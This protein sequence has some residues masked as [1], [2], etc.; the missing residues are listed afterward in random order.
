MS[1]KNAEECQQRREQA[2]MERPLIWT[3]ATRHFKIFFRKVKLYAWHG[4][5]EEW[6][7]RRKVYANNSDYIFNF[8]CHHDSSLACPSPSLSLSRSPFCRFIFM[9]FMII[10]SKHEHIQRG[11]KAKLQLQISFLPYT[12]SRRFSHLSAQ[13]SR[14]QCTHILKNNFVKTV[15]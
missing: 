15:F 7:R 4:S 11:S 3:R 9:F 2:K 12:C 8:R 10:Q 6:C 14:L 5:D 13:A 1:R